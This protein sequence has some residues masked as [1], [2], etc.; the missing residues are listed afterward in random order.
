MKMYDIVVNLCNN[1]KGMVIDV[2]NDIIQVEFWDYDKITGEKYFWTEKFV[3]EELEL[4][5]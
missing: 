3:E 4:V 5:Y 1:M 2:E